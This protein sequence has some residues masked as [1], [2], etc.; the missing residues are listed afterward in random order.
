MSAEQEQAI[1][2]AA[3]W[4]GEADRLTL[5]RLGSEWMAGVRMLEQPRS[6]DGYH[7]SPAEAL[8]IA[9]EMTC[10]FDISPRVVV[11]FLDAHRRLRL[12]VAEFSVRAALGE[13]NG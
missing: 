10:F 1:D 11:G 7:K 13:R 6:Y 12:A 4:M 2:A 3:G 8:M 9:A 5:V